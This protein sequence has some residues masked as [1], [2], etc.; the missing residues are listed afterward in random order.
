MKKQDRKVGFYNEKVERMGQEE[1]G[2]Y[3]DGIIQNLLDYAYKNS[4]AYKR[5]LD[6]ADIKPGDIKT[7]DDLV[8]VP[9]TKR[10]DI[11]EGRKRNPPFGEFCA[12][13]PEQVRRIFVSPGPMFHPMLEMTAGTIERLRRLF[14]SLG[15]RPGDVVLNTFMYTMVPAGM[16]F[17][18]GLTGMGCIVIPGG[19]GNTDIQIDTL[20][21]MPVNGYVGTPSFLNIIGD[22]AIERGFD[23]RKDFQ[24]EIG[25][26]T[27]EMLP[28]SLRTELQGKF[29]MLVR[30][31]YGTADTGMLCYECG[32][33]TGM[34]FNDDAII[35]LIDPGTGERVPVGETGVVVASNLSP[36]APVIRFETGDLGIVTDE[37]CTC[38]RTSLRLLKLVGRSDQVTKVR[39]MFVH[40]TECEQVISR[41]PEI[42]RF[43]IVVTRE[44][45]QDKLTCLLELKEEVDREKLAEKVIEGLKDTIKIRADL[46]YIAPGTL[47]E[48]SKK[49]DDKRVW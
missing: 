15:F 14:F 8:K 29:D 2:K 30:Q 49:L 12:V 39:G 20:K 18:L 6:Q 32:E 47:S 16:L 19:V 25:L 9:I 17:D 40:A 13:G 23:P 24:L 4:P 27:A 46:E 7:Y 36:E 31:V 48:W 42:A 26:S 34:H 35:E 37:P 11:V 22:R 10:E 44:G 43:Q 21:H 28:E 45:H 1:R 3:Q 38:G 33:L 41:F 5:I